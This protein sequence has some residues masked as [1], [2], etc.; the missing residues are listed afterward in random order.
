[1]PVLLE[2]HDPELTLRPE[3]TK[4]DIV[5]YLYQNP[6][7]GYSPQDLKEALDIPRGTATTTL[8][9]LYD[10]GYIGKTDDGYYHALSDRED[11][12]R[13]VSSLDQ[14]HRLFGHHRDS[15]ATP[16]EPEKQIG[17][18]RS[19]EELDAELAEL[20]DGLEEVDE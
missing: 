3:T 8:K 15:D 19:D 6:E 1:M 2:D 17:E 13:Y 10:D 18:G 14:V 16:E 9:R 4:S 11:I 12:R 20:E 5:A 7:W